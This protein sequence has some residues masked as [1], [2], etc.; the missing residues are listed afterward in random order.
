M[1]AGAYPGDLHPAKAAAKIRAILDVGVTCFLD[2][3]EHD[4]LHPYEPELRAEA[5]ARRIAVRH[6]RR[7]IRDMRT[8]VPREMTAIMQAIR[9]AIA[10]GEKV[11]VHCWG[12]IGRTGTVVGCWLVEQGMPPDEALT[13]VNALFRTMSADKVARHSEG[14]PQTH[15][16]RAMVRTWRQPGASEA[17]ETRGNA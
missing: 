8:C 2:L 9:E 13:T 14:S 15:A 16:Q 3:T 1:V 5:E 11:Y 7:P 10:A 12:G 6:V 4:E 17:R